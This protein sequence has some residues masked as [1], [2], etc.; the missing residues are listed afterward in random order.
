MEMACPDKV[1]ARFTQVNDTP[2]LTPPLITDL[3]LL[4]C[5]NPNFNPIAAGQYQPLAGTAPSAAKL[6]HHLKQPNEVPD[7]GLHLTNTIHSEGWKKAKERMA[8]SLSGAHFGHYKAGTFS[9]L[10]NSMHTALSAIPLKTGYSYH[11]W[12]KG[13]NM[14]LE[15]SL[16]NFQVNKL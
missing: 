7:C 15:K 16:G 12:K 1:R 5:Y 9:K 13:I 6:L 3:G 11:R 4:N 14:M 2:F 8:S 10:I